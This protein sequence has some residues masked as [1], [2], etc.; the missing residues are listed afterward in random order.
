MDYYFR[1]DLKNIDHT[2]SIDVPHCKNMLCLNESPYDPYQ[3]VQDDFQKIMKKVRLNRYFSEIT[4]ELQ[5]ELI[6]YVGS[7][8]GLKNIIFGNGADEMLYY[9]F[10]SLRNSP[11]DYILS[12]SPSYFDYKSYSRATGMNVK[13][14]DLNPDFGFDLQ[15]YI[16]LTRSRHCRL[17]ILCNPNNPTGNLLD[18]EKILEVINRVEVPVLIDETYYEF[19]KVTLLEEA[20]KRDDL[21][22][23]RSF[24]KAFSAAGLRFGYILG[25]EKLISE[26]AKVKTAFNSSILVQAFALAILKNKGSFLEIVEEICKSRDE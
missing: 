16:T 10:T 24:S 15:K 23:I 12:L 22:I 11:E 21:L 9:L 6:N 2:V 5:E 19:S 1:K 20:M 25:N 3:I 14:L 26:I 4:G 17:A 7:G 18:R 13:F 8:V